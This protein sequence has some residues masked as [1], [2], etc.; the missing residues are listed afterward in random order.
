MKVL[1]WL[2]LLA[3]VCM[4]SSIDPKCGQKQQIECQDDINVAYPVCKKAAE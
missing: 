2:L 1:T 3:L 4:A